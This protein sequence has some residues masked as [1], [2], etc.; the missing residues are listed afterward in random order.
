MPK[1]VGSAVYEA[2][3]H[4]GPTIPVFQGINDGSDWPDG[5]QPKVYVA[6]SWRNPHQPKTVQLLL[7]AGAA[8]Y[9]FR[10]PLPGDHGFSWGDL[11]A[12]WQGWSNREY[13]AALKHPIAQAGFN[14]DIT[15][16][17]ECS[18]CVLVAPCGRSAHLELG[19]AVG[20]GKQTAVL[21]PEE[22]QEPE[23]MLS[24]CDLI[25]DNVGEVMAW[26]VGAL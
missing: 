15:A 20:A 21:L 18:H 19:F 9:D 5:M 4:R 22:P 2:Q 12:E 23:L 16:L 25:T 6:S 7:H 26:M 1:D 17:R 10:H 3:E 14:S 11:A 8:V 13:I 24:M